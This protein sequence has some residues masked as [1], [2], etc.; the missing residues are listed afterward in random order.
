MDDS[1]YSYQSAEYDTHLMYKLSASCV[2]KLHSY[3]EQFIV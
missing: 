3:R 2:F 1:S